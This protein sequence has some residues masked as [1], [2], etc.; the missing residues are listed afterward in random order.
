MYLLIRKHVGV[1]LGI[2]LGAELQR[3]KTSPLSQ[4]PYEP[5]GRIGA[6]TWGILCAEQC[7]RQCWLLWG[8]WWDTDWGRAGEGQCPGLVTL[9]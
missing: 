6:Q 1:V 5:I 4:E 9:S 8:S 2:A 7:G 3:Q